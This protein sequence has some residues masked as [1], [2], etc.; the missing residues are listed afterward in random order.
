[1]TELVSK[2]SIEIRKGADGRYHGKIAYRYPV[3]VVGELR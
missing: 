1:M 2:Q 3:P